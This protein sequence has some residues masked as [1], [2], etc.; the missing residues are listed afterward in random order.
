MNWRLVLVATWMGTAAAC[1][2]STKAGV[3][4]I[5]NGSFESP[6]TTFVEI[7]VDS[8]QKSP[9]PDW[10]VEGG[11]FL[12]TQLVGAF[13]N[14]PAGNSDH[15]DN[16]DG[17]QAAWLFAV[18]EAGF[19]QD[20]NSVDW[21]DPQPTHAFDARFE[22]GKSYQ[23]TVGVIGGGGGM[24]NGASVEISLYY[25]D[26]ASNKVTVTSTLIRNSPSVFSNRT[27]L[28]DFQA[29]VPTVQ[30]TDPW[31]GRHI[32]VQILST[33]TTNLQGGY[34]DFDN[35]RLF[36]AAAPQLIGG[37]L[38]DGQFTLTLQS[39]PGL[40]FEILAS[41]EVARSSSAWTSVGNVTNVTGT[42]SFTDAMA[43]SSHKFYQ[44]RL[45]P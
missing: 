13:K 24:S 1:L 29:D 20:Y 26:T 38:A 19:F 8:W 41:S 15:I 27:Q 12:W 9:K 36:S 23:L 40:R 14:T 18:P 37:T 25:R 34:W 28:V 11:G 42:V 30:G 35:V 31:A 44:A 45:L 22:V 17:Q 6:T 4:P 10:Y 16:C 21:D 3:I 7:N 2:G 5:P 33:V 32:G 43:N 39:E